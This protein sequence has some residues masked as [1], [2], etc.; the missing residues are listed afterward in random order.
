M[1]FDTKLFRNLQYRAAVIVAEVNSMVMLNHTC[2]EVFA[3][4][5]L[6]WEAF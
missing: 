3:E 1:N 2:R 5:I 6:Q 4:L